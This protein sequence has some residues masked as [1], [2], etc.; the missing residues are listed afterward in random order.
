V[1]VRVHV[2]KDMKCLHHE[3]H[4]GRACRPIWLAISRFLSN[5]WLDSLLH[6]TQLATDG[7]IAFMEAALVVWTITAL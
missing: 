3:H 5:A 4:F 6:V 1:F 7:T 2:A